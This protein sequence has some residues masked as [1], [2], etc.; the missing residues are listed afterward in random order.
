MSRGDAEEHYPYNVE[1]AN[2][3]PDPR[4]ILVDDSHCPGQWGGV[5]PLGPPEGINNG[6]EQPK[7]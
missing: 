3:G 6:V 2:A 7:A 1:G 5:G 4:V